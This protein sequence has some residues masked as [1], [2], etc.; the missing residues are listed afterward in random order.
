[1]LIPYIALGL[2]VVFLILGFYFMV[3]TI[4][5]VYSLLKGSPFVKTKSD[6]IRQ[7]LKAANIKKG[8]KLVDLGCGD[9]VVVRMAA[10]EYGI[11]AVGVDI[12]FILLARANIMKKLQGLKTA[13]F[14]NQNIFDTDI[15]SADIIYI[16]LLPK[17]LVKIKDKLKNESKKN[18]LIISHGF[19]IDGWDEYLVNTIENKPF[20]TFL[21]K[22][23]DDKA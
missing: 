10:K 2:L 16:F 5:L 4:M 12:N 21:Y 11:E 8:M 14:L 7:V 15:A 20:S 13:S 6:A 3:N 19:Q 17:F 18:A 22:L 1:M 23:T 9:G